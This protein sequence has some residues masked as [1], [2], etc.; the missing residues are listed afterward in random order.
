MDGRKGH[1]EVKRKR[2]EMDLLQ[3]QNCQYADEQEEYYTF[4]TSGLEYLLAALR[5]MS[6]ENFSMVNLTELTKAG[7]INTYLSNIK[8][9]Q[10]Y[11]DEIP[12]V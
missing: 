11:K 6:E 5:H 3:E 8:T 10:K 9:V 2:Q 12:S 1:S 7:G 4:I